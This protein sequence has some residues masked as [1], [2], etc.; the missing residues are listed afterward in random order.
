MN[1][2][3]VIIYFDRNVRRVCARCEVQF[4]SSDGTFA[5]EKSYD[6]LVRKVRME[7]PDL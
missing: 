5:V 2:L 4:A 6:S 1:L 7:L 3:L